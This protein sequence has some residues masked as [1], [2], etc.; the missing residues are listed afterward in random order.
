MTKITKIEFTSSIS[1]E[2]HDNFCK[3]IIPYLENWFE[4]QLAVIV[5]M[6]KLLNLKKDEAYFEVEL[7]YKGRV[8]T[9]S[10]I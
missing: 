3:A 7:T 10:P 6:K 9:L 8:I 4:I 1:I 2:K 5:E